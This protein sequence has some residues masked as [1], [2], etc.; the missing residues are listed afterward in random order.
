MK[1]KKIG[2]GLIVVLCLIQVLIIYEL[3]E[4]SSISCKYKLEVTYQNGETNTMEV[5]SESSIIKGLYLINGDLSIG[6]KVISSGVRDYCVLF[7]ECK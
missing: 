4:Q 5:E 1:L 6:K 2:I 3:I 7:K